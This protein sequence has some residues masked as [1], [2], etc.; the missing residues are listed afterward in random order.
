M[1]VG[2]NAAAGIVLSGDNGDPFAIKFESDF[3]K[4]LVDG[5]E[6][7]FE[8]FGAEV[9]GIE[10]NAPRFEFLDFSFDGAGND[11]ARCEFEAVIV[12]VHESAAI[13]IAEGCSG[14]AHCFGDEKSGEL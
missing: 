7:V 1:K 8:F 13:V 10:I 3:E 11:V 14:P 4:A 5:G 9:C 2:D 12:V 6:F